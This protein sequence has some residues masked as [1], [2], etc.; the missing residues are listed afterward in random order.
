LTC[1]SVSHGLGRHNYYLSPDERVPAEK[2]LFI[3]Q[4]PFAWALTC[5]KISIALLLIRIQH[6]NRLW[7]FFLYGMVIIQVL[8]G[9]T[10]NTFQLLLCKPLA[11]VWDKTIPNYVCIP[12]VVQT[13]IYVTA[14]LT[15]LTDVI[16]SLLPLTFIRHVWRSVWER[17]AIVFIM[18]LGLVASCASIYKMTLI[19]NY[20]ITGDTLFC[21]V[22][23]S[24]WSILEIQLAI[25]AACIPCLKQLFER[26]L[27]SLGLILTRTTEC[28][29]QGYVNHKDSSKTPTQEL[30]IIQSVEPIGPALAFDNGSRRTNAETARSQDLG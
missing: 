23:L 25:I 20:H 1:I 29:R 4:P 10:I 30:S 22:G 16:L 11:A 5:A 19:Y 13:S 9:I 26:T 8:I 28:N 14:I 21:I 6:S 15:I 7:V 27:N 18:G 2:F 12:G 3:S 24:F 17:I